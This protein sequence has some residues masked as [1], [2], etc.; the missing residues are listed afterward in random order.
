MANALAHVVLATL[1]KVASAR[2]EGWLNGS[3]GGNPVGKSVFA[4]LDD[5]VCAPKSALAA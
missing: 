1:G 5:T 2:A 4:V 3:V